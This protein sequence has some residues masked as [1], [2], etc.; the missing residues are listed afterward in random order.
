MSGY[1]PGLIGI[2]IAVAALVAR[3]ALPIS[4]EH[5]VGLYGLAIFA[6]GQY[7]G[8][9]VAPR[10]AM[11]GE[12][13]RILYVHVPAAWIAMVLFTVA[14]GGA[15]GALLRQL[16]DTYGTR[17]VGGITL[18]LV[19]DLG[20]ALGTDLPT[21]P[22]IIVGLLGWAAVAALATLVRWVGWTIDDFDHLG[23]AATEAGVVMCG[24]L[25]VLGAIFARPTWGVFWTWDP[26]LTASAIMWLT[27]VGVMLLR[28]L[29]T[30]REVRALWA[31]AA[32]LLAFVN[33]PITYMAV[34]WWRSMHQMQ[35]S[36]S[37][38]SDEMYI[39]LRINA[40]A[41]LFLGA[42]F[43]ARRWRI[44]HALAAAEAPPPLPEPVV[45]EALP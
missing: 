25:L 43:V 3:R 18:L 38:M 6:V 32:T 39:I 42:W 44:A 31:S 9:F 45:A 4:W 34:R 10:E 36:T 12:V 24:L 7:M 30:D 40:W 20:L 2:I 14:F 23:E 22:L 29:I 16:F 15:L 21:V 37:T 27:F 17:F 8:L 28:A 1:E 11:M 33:I 41:F 35:S 5:L 26:R 13:S 19:V